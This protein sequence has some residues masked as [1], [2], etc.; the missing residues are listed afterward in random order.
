ME[1]HLHYV[2]LLFKADEIGLDFDNI[3]KT[4][5]L[6]YATALRLSD[7]GYTNSAQ[8]DLKIGFNSLDEYLTGLQ[9]A[10]N[11]PSERFAQVRSES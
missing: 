7:L 3:G 5:Y 1:L 10:M 6:P 9:N 2:L 4:L 11:K 8:S